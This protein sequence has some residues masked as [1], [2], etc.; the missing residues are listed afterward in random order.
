MSHLNVCCSCFA[1]TV[2]GSAILGAFFPC[3]CPAEWERVWSFPTFLYTLWVWF[4]FLI[5]WISGFLFPYL[6]MPWIK[7]WK[8]RF[9]RSVHG[10]SWM[11]P[12][13]MDLCNRTRGFW[14]LSFLFVCCCC[15]LFQEYSTS[16]S[17]FLVKGSC[18]PKRESDAVLHTAILFITLLSL[19]PQRTLTH[20]LYHM[21]NVSGQ[22]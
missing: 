2:C 12:L 4:K 8:T 21:R 1:H 17:H 14:S 11:L 22:K 6:G 18:F 10:H 16:F 7:C 15:F 19:L 3:C 9:Y 13:F 20:N 5:W